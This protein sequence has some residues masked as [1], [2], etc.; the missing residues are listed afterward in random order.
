L[1]AKW[2]GLGHQS[3][4]EMTVWL[5][6][7]MSDHQPNYTSSPWKEK[8]QIREVMFRVSVMGLNLDEMQSPDEQKWRQEYDEGIKVKLGKGMQ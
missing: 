3:G 2:S 8:S 5:G 6:K 4:Y 1:G 7:L